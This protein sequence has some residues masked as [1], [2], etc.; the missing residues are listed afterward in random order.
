MRRANGVCD[1]LAVKAKAS[2]ASGGLDSQPPLIGAGLVRV[3]E[4]PVVQAY[5]QATKHIHIEPIQAG[6]Q[7]RQRFTFLLVLFDQR[8]YQRDDN[9]PIQFLP[10]ESLSTSGNVTRCES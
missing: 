10:S 2:A 8:F 9:L 1:P 6:P 4:N 5:K 7:R 3:Q